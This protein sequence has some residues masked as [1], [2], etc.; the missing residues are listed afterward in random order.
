MSTV[1]IIS[2]SESDRVQRQRREQTASENRDQ[3]DYARISTTPVMIRVG[4]QHGT[5]LLVCNLTRN[6][7]QLLF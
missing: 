1:K 2:T 7:E 5:I 3:C 4:K 6:T